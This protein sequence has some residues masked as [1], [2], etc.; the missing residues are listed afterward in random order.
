MPILQLVQLT[1]DYQEA[2]L[3]KDVSFELG[4]GDLLHLQG[5]N[6]AGKT[7]LLKVLA[8]LYEPSSGEI[9]YQGVPITEQLTTYQQDLCFVGHKIGISPYLT[10][11]ENCKF[12]IHYS[13]QKDLR[14]L[15]ALFHLQRYLTTPCGLLSAGQRRQVGLLRLWLT[16]AKIWLLDEPF[17]ALDRAALIILMDKIQQHRETGGL[18]LLTSH[19]EIP[20]EVS[21]YKEYCL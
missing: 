6:G 14:E 5:A 9:N 1:F 10:L 4:G 20:L 2:P 21:S 7:T 19:Q 8:G 11:E 16:K 18:V 13:Q 15:A 12:D 17:V 3:L